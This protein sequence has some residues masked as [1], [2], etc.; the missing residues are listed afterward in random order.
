MILLKSVS[1]EKWER[2][3]NKRKNLNLKRDPTLLRFILQFTHFVVVLTCALLRF[4]CKKKSEK[5][6]KVKEKKHFNEMWQH[7]V[8]FK[9]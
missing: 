3:R 1:L 4:L 2:S 7:V 5:S 8:A 9:L 6:E